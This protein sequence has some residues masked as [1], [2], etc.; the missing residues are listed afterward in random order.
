MAVFKELDPIFSSKKGAS[1]RIY[2]DAAQGALYWVTNEHLRAILPE[3]VSPFFCTDNQVIV[4]FQFRI[5]LDM[6][7]G[8]IPISLAD[9]VRLIQYCLDAGLFLLVDTSLCDS[10]KLTLENSK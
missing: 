5:Q 1:D 9:T 2:C 6:A 4:E 8:S 3:S 10:S 7:P